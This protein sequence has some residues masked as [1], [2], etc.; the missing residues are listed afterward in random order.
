MTEQH[1]ML[2]RQS[3]AHQMEI[4]ASGGG[5]LCTYP[6]GRTE[7]TYGSAPYGRHALSAWAFA[8]RH[9]AFVNGRKRR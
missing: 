7:L 3:R 8:K 5:M 2:F 9:A 6:S 4:A 1:K